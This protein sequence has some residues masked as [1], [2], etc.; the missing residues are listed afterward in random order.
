MNQS[1]ERFGGLDCVIVDDLPAGHS[2]RTLAV[3]CHGY[4]ATGT[5]L[6]P[7]GGEILRSIPELAERVRFVFPAAPLSLS[8]A[9]YGGRAWWHLDIEERLRTIESGQER[10]LCREHPPGLDEAAE[11]LTAAVR[12]A[13]DM[14]GVPL[15][16]CV[17]GGFSQGAMVATHVALALPERIAALAIFS[18]TL[19][20]EDHWT[21]RLSRRGP[22]RVLMSHGRQDPILPFRGAEWLRDAFEKAGLPVEFIPFNGPHTIPMPAVAAYAAM[23]LAVSAVPE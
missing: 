16:Q 6:V 1:R 10:L 11:K 9:G 14:A 4:G 20:C 8:A 21:D 5:D 22:L 2:P 3:L 17:L 18:G 15:E 19:L 23:L 7:I 12:E 13:A